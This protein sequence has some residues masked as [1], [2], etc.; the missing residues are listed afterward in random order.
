MMTDIAIIGGG[1]AGAAVFGEILQRQRACTI[2]WIVGASTPGRGV[3]YSTD[4]DR[5]LL[6]VR[7][8]KM[9]LFLHQ[10]DDFLAHASG[11]LDGVSGSD[12]LPRRLFGDFVQAQVEALILA[13]RQQGQSVE[14][15]AANA[16][17]LARALDGRYRIALHDGRNVEVDSAVLALGAL[18]PRALGCVTPKARL[19]GAYRLDPWNLAGGTQTPRRVIVIGTGLT[20]VDTLLTASTRW[21]GAQL[22]A[23]SRHGLLPRVHAREALAAYP[24]QQA[25][26]DDLLTT[27]SIPQIMRKVRLAIAANGGEWRSIIDGMRPI[28]SLLW[29]GFNTRQRWQF[30]RH[31]RWIWESARHRLPPAS[32]DAIAQ[33]REEGRLQIF[34]ARV[35]AV[36]DGAPLRMTVREREWQLDKTL[37]SDLVIQATGLDTAC[38]YTEDPL[39]SRLLEQGMAA[40][41]LL[42]LGIGTEVDGQIR[43]RDGNAQPGLYAIGSLLRGSLW[44]CTAMPEIRKAAHG[45]ANRLTE[46]L[47][48]FA[49]VG[50]TVGP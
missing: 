22:V 43:D 25:L 26:N 6:N 17:D 49:R 9:G 10:P 45:V 40:P 46:H 29:Q 1:A 33:L 37:E 38:A 36:D 24:D 7:A 13:A 48:S 31:A 34:A 20:A 19:S 4:D 39:I 28:N 14:I 47:L 8:D 32:H 5:H 2:H 27:R 41:D 50:E 35:L 12:F 3:A 16:V 44:E 42:Q 11:E 15:H 30:L 18:P 21:P 23:V